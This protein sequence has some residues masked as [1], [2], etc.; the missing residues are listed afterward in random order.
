MPPHKDGSNAIDN[1]QPTCSRCIILKRS[2]YTDYRPRWAP[3]WREKLTARVT[4]G[5]YGSRTV[6]LAVDALVDARERQRMPVEASTGIHMDADGC[7]NQASTGIHGRHP[8]TA[9]QEKKGSKNKKKKK[10][11]VDAYEKHATSTSTSTSTLPGPSGGTPP[12]PPVTGT[13]APAGGGGL[14]SQASTTNARPVTAETWDAYRSAYVHRYGVEPVRNATVNAQL[15]MLV[16]RVG[17]DAAPH[18]AAFYVT[19]N[20]SFYV[21]KSHSVGP[22][23]KDA[24]ALHTQWRRHAP[25]TVEAARQ[26]DRTASNAG[27][28]G[29]LLE[30]ARSREGGSGG[31]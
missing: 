30:E 3:D 28:F 9:G 10:S 4:G 23:V 12:V 24:E 5:E 17:H 15:G 13:A 19:V 11:A 29:A 1:I 31:A 21:Q 2:D 27:A 26:A 20:H 25:M 18:V 14:T 8:R 6:M 7:P 16:K 22:M